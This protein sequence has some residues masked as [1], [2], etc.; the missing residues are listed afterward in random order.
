MARVLNGVADQKHAS[1]V[2]VG[3]FAQVKDWVE[4]CMQSIGTRLAD[5]LYG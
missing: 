1:L 2:L 4:P 5:E 3:S